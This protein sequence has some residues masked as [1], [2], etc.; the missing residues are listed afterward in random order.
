MANMYSME[1]RKWQSEN[2]QIW[3]KT[4]KKSAGANWN[5]ILLGVGDHDKSMSQ[6]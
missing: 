6:I 1:T 4:Q 3:A 2:S 5:Y